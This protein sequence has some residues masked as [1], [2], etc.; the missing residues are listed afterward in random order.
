MIKKAVDQNIKINENMRGGDGSI[1][2]KHIADKTE[3]YDK[4][5]LYA[6]I[7]IKPGCSIGYHVHENEGE[8]FYIIAGTALYD[9]NGVQTELSTGDTAITPAGHG[10]SIANGGTGDVELIALIVLQ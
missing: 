5:R 8:I 9:D 1:I 10:H 2:I 6:H 7:V 4:N 3:M